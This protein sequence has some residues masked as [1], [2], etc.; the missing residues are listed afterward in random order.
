MTSFSI[1]L[2]VGP[3]IL[4]LCPAIQAQDAYHVEFGGDGYGNE[5][6]ILVNDS[7]TPIE[8]YFLSFRCGDGRGGWHNGDTLS[9]YREGSFSIMSPIGTTSY[10]DVVAPGKRAIVGNHQCDTSVGAVLFSDGTWAGDELVASGLKAWRDG[11]VACLDEWIG[12]LV[13][14]RAAMPLEPLKARASVRS[15]GDLD[16]AG[17][18]PFDPTTESGPPAQEQYWSGKFQVDWSLAAW[19]DSTASWHV[20]APSEALMILRGWKARID[21]NKAMQELEAAFPKITPVGELTIPI[22]P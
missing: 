19:F 3:V 11:V 1:P 22:A 14:D 21:G 2:L 15:Q 5:D 4:A 9:G 20:E 8:A 10:A 6:A 18:Y 12:F 17:L 16:R 13:R 7:K